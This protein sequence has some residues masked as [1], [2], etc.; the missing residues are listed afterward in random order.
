MP[1]DTHKH[2][3]SLSLSL[4]LGAHINKHTPLLQVLGIVGIN[5]FRNKSLWL[6]LFNRSFL[7]RIFWYYCLILQ[8]DFY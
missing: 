2:I 6:G 4:T 5:T 3:L 1:N 8:N 7:V